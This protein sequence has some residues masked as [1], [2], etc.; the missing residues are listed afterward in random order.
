MDRQ[1]AIEYLKKCSPEAFLLKAKKRGFIC[2]K[3]GNGS[4][5]DGDGIV[6]NPKDGR[7]HCFRCGE[8]HGDIFDLVGAAFGLENFEDQFKKAASIYGVTVEKMLKT[9]VLSA[10]GNSF[11]RKDELPSDAENTADYLRKCS[12]RL[13]ET[14]YFRSRGIPDELAKRFGMGFDPSF[15]MGTSVWQ[16]AVL[17]VGNGSYELRNTAV[18]PDAKGGKYRK[19]GRSAVFNLSPELL[20]KKC[21]VFVCEGIFDA[22]SIIR[23]G[24]EAVALCS[25]ANHRLLVEEIDKNGCSC[26]PVLLLD[27]DETGKQAA[28]KL[29]SAFSEREIYF[30][31]GSSLLDGFHDVNERLLKDQGGLTADISRLTEELS[32]SEN[33]GD[34]AFFSVN[35]ACCLDEF[36]K[37][38]ERSALS[39]AVSTGFSSLDEALSGGLRAGL[40]IFGAVS[41][42][43]KTTLLLQIA[44]N[45][46]ASGRDVLFFS[47]E[48][49]RFEL[50]SKS[51][52]RESFRF[53]RENRL[54]T[55]NAKS[56]ME[57]S[58]G[59]CHKRF[60]ETEQYVVEGAFSAY[61][62]YASRIF[63]Y[64]CCGGFSVG[65]IKEEMKRYFAF[66]GRSGEMPVV[67]LDY[68][69]MLRPVSDRLSDKQA[70]DRNIVALKQL[71]RDYDLP[72]LAVSSLNRA[73]YAREVNME[74]FKESGAIE[75]GA[76]VLVGLQFR[77]VGEQGFDIKAAKARSPRQIELA[78]LKNRSGR[79]P[80]SP[81]P[82]SYFAE[83]NCFVEK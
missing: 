76:D 12:E 52:S 56:S 63:L 68:L 48:Q 49:S 75:Y 16:A 72:L 7:Y 27:G 30:R 15:S 17:P 29:A 25:A 26:V 83:Y 54:K 80:A 14:D 2:P 50:M 19:C 55:S 18:S 36:R 32:L 81:L 6:I 28:D 70:V 71:S 13:S 24:G 58:D 65:D 9:P 77:G 22:L 44:D 23:C 40:Y 31:D 66:P 5:K 79:I 42:L 34:D 3:C 64:E 69:Q 38:I 10:S 61:E 11:S 73:N 43:G 53:C 82:F 33:S 35:A 21:P 37:R 67:V 74:A 78:I 51:I 8:L 60:D 47:L 46:A 41:S 57:I 4:G 39:P 62:K 45:I 59:C 20:R 1:N